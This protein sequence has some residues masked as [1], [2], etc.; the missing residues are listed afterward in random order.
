MI[1]LTVVDALFYRPLSTHSPARTHRGK[2]VP[3]HQAFLFVERKQE[4]QSGN[5]NVLV[6][7]VGSLSVPLFGC[8]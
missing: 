5:V 3:K 6:H 8:V 2:V 4:K 7:L 1:V